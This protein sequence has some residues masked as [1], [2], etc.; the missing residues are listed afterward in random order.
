MSV[1]YNNSDIKL[2]FDDVMTTTDSLT[3]LGHSVHTFYTQIRQNRTTYI[4]AIY[5]NTITH[6]TV[7][8]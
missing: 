3:F 6:C 7:D 1:K 8:S 5:I 4:I 2:T